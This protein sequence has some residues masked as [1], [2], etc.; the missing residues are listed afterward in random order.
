MKVGYEVEARF[1]SVPSDTEGSEGKEKASATE[2][3]GSVREEFKDNGKATVSKDKGYRGEENVM[4]QG[5]R[6]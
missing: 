3:E 6:N 4:A 1:P 2:G 5:Q